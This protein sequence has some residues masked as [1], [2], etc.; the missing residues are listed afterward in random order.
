MVCRYTA[1]RGK[2]QGLQCSVRSGVC[3]YTCIVYRR[4]RVWKTVLI[5]PELG[6]LIAGA[7][8]K[9][10]C[11]TVS[12][13][14]LGEPATAVVPL[15]IITISVFQDAHN[16]ELP[17][18]SVCC[19]SIIQYISLN[20]KH[21]ENVRS[22]MALGRIPSDPDLRVGHSDVGIPQSRRKGNFW[23][24]NCFIDIRSY[25][26]HLYLI[27]IYLYIQYYML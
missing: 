13:R 17:R 27:I 6:A 9:R 26:R 18:P 11:A 1:D 25:N 5:F 21:D 12:A 19:S 10:A 4:V 2:C 7:V 3:I 22:P 23:K 16:D 20:S 14:R 8:D 15:R 24:L